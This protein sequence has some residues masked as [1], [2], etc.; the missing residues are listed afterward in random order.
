MLSFMAD[1]VF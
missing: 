1:G